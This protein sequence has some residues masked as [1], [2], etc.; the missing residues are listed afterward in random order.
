VSYDMFNWECERRLVQYKRRDMKAVTGRLQQVC[1][2]LR[3]GEDHTV[4]TKFGGSVEKGAYAPGLSDVDALLIVNQSSLRNRPPAEVIAYIREVI[5]RHLPNNRVDTGKLA[6]TVGYRDRTEIQIL[7]AIRTKGGF[8]IADP[9]SDEWS[10]VVYPER[11]VER[12][13]EVNNARGGRVVPTIKLAK[14]IADCHVTRPSRKIKG[15]H[16]EALAIGAFGDYQGALDPK[17]TL[18]RL[19]SYAM[20][21][22]MGP[23]R[24]S[25]GQ[26]LQV[27][28][29]SARRVHWSASGLRRISDRCGARS[30][31]AGRRRS[32]TRF[33]VRGVEASARDSRLAPRLRQRREL[34]LSPRVRGNR[35][36]SV[37]L[38]FAIVP[39]S[40]AAMFS[41]PQ[42][43]Q[44]RQAD[45]QREE[46][47]SFRLDTFPL[48][49]RFQYE[50]VVV[51]ADF[52]RVDRRRRR[53][54]LHA[55]DQRLQ[56][57]LCEL[58]FQLVHCHPLSPIACIQCMTKL[59][60]DLGVGRDFSR[61]HKQTALRSAPG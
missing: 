57:L 7:P 2:I 32:S 33:F 15:H 47:G 16:L 42:S 31:P 22:V 14:A 43:P 5:Q 25:T 20:E 34:G 12:L 23:I 50:L 38:S 46:Q 26:S 51:V 27:T 18:D 29:I 9:G 4:Q 21:A 10:D 11:F 40:V 52:D 39:P 45:L 1:S 49:D 48:A 56:V 54:V 13:I 3:H 6:V 24:D 17:A 41:F 37:A 35:S 53:F 55:V 58:E 59:Q 44:R 30:E 61:M 19:F 36:D 8:R 28:G 60:A